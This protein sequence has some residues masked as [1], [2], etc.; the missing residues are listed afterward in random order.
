MSE[1][2]QNTLEAVE[3]AGESRLNSAIAI[4]VL[5]AATFMAVCNLKDGNIVQGMQQA[6]ARSIDQWSY[7]QAKG[8]KQNI[9]EAFADQLELERDMLRDASP[10]QRAAIERK[11]LDYKRRVASY[12]TEKKQ[13]KHA[14]EAAER[15]YDELN[16]R[17]DQFDAAEACAS[18]GIAL[19]GV[20]ALTRKRRLLAVGIAFAAIGIAFGLSGFL[21]W[22]LH[23]A[24]LSRILG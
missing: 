24:F 9:A 13:I 20:T 6:Q 16:V 10:E 3:K 8:T 21:G 1:L 15:Q 23:P 7:Y 4:L 14:A 18:I 17:D 22:N 2:E 5:L 12:E 11:L 19:F